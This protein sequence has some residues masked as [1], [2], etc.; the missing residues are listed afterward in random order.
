MH[1]TL[2]QETTR[3]AAKNVLQQQERF[4]RFIECYK[5]ERP[6]QADCRSVGAAHSGPTGPSELRRRR[7]MNPSSAAGPGPGAVV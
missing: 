2:K 6:H 4:D 5:Q 3:P 1:L 7:Q